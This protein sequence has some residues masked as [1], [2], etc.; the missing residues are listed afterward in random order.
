MGK[1]L[2]LVIEGYGNVME[3]L[4]IKKTIPQ[5]LIDIAS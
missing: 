3:E 1:E 4:D 5:Q 2:T